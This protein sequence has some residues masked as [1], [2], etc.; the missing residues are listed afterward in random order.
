MAGNASLTKVSV[1]YGL[2]SGLLGSLLSIALFYMGHHPLLAPPFLDFRI[3]L[4]AIVI[5]FALK[6]FRDFHNKG[7]LY[8]WQGMMGGLSITLGF[9]PIASGLLYLFAQWNATFVEQYIN[10]SLEQIKNFSPED[11]ERIGKTTFDQSLEA[12]KQADAYF[13]A[14][15]YLVQSFVLSFFIT[16]IISVILRNQPKQ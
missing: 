10:L 3:L 8:F 13:L 1:R 14:S 9:A 7:I 11:I 4:F 5:F 12:L 2:L 6:E 16:I 15:R